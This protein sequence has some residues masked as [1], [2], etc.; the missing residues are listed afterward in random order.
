MN[1]NRTNHPETRI[2]SEQYAKMAQDGD[3]EAFEALVKRHEK[4]I[5]NLAYTRT[6][7]HDDSFDIAQETFL[8]AY[9]ALSGFRSESSFSTWIYRICLNVI[10]DHQKKLHNRRAHETPLEYTDSDGSEATYDLPDDTYNPEQIALQ[11]ERT[12]LVRSEIDKLNEKYRV[13]LVMRDINGLSYNKI[14]EVLG[15]ELGTVKSR[16][17]RA[18]DSLKE[19]LEKTGFV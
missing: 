16:I 8:R 3:V 12:R 18:R 19:I 4:G 13:P 2:S 6:Y 15:L 10:S 11:N 7:N 17:K 14:S 9:R 1:R 5:Y